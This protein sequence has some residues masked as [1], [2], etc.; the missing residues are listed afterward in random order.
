VVI[1]LKIKLLNGVV[2]RR[3]KHPI[4]LPLSENR[5]K[6]VQDRLGL[7]LNDFGFNLGAKTLR[8]L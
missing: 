6:Q 1:G 2:G 5:M 3:S 7:A 8:L 4:Y